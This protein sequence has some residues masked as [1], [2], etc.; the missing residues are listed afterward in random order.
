MMHLIQFQ[1]LQELIGKTKDYI[2]QLKFENKKLQKENGELK[3]ILSEKNNQVPSNLTEKIE[4]LEEENRS[5]KRK[6][7]RVSIRLVNMLD[8]VKSLSE[9]VES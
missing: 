7:K 5:L 4:R 3:R 6:H 1:K 9:G 2:I 8:R